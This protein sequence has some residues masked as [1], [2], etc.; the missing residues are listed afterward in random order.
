MTDGI[1]PPGII[2]CNETNPCTGFTFDNVQASGWWSFLRMN[3]ITENVYGEVRNS[4]PKPA[5]VSAEGDGFVGN[6][7]LY[8][9]V[10]NFSHWFMGL[11]HKMRE[12]E[13]F[14]NSLV[15]KFES[16]VDFYRMLH[17]KFTH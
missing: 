10:Q 16:V 17:D 7:N 1:L 4:H 13:R 9:H 8:E 14:Q 3:F 6:D 15:D 5:F 12:L 11:F 2:R